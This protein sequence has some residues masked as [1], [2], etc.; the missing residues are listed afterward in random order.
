MRNVIIIGGV[1]AGCKAAARLSRLCPDYQ[2]TI[3]EKSEFISFSSCGLPFYASGDLNDLSDLNKTSY[4]IVRDSK[5]FQEVK[6][7]R[8]LIETEVLKL[9][10]EKKKVNCKNFQT[11]DVFE[12]QYDYL[13]LSTG[14]EAVKPKFAYP[15]TPLI[16]SFHTPADAKYFRQLAQ[17][18]KIR[19]AVIVG[20][21]FVGCEMI[22]ALT[23]LW[24]IETVMIE[25]EKTILSS[26][27]DPEISSFVE[28][29]IKHDNIHLMLGNS[30]N[31]IDVDESG[32]PVVYLD[33]GQIISSDFVL[34]N[35]GVMPNSS[36]AKEA[37]IKVGKCGGII[38][39]E[40][41]RTS[42]PNI[43]AAG[44]CV[45]IK[46]FVKDK[47]DYFSLGSLSNR[48]GRAAADS[49]AGTSSNNNHTSF[50]GSAGTVSLKMFD[51]IIC[52]SGLT[53][54]KAASLGYKT[55]SVIGC[56][57]DRPDY[58]PDSKNI[59]GKLV[60]EKLGMKLLG[61]Q[62]VSE[63]EVTRYI[64]L[65]SEMLSQNKSV[66]D[67]LNTEHAYTPAH[68]NPVS[69]LNYLG[70]MAINQEEDGVRCF[71]PLKI[72][73]FSGTFIDVR[74]LSETDSS[75]N[76]FPGYKYPDRTIQAPLSNLRMNLRNFNIEQPLMFICEKGV[77]S[78]EAA[79]I[80]KNHGYK[81]ISYLGGG[82]LLY[83]NL[84]TQ[85]AL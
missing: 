29:C 45:E 20:G 35:L 57:Y 1:A 34:Y 85:E 30:V 5:Y 3:I 65:F 54:Q 62:L 79:R 50:K 82:S 49:I 18:G 48:M 72:P 7:V 66:E 9:D 81:N 76:K 71:C 67:L 56:W 31:K 8:A 26:I 4:G 32:L 68:S 39:D 11:G 44:D 27:L 42:A 12:L 64:D 22:E 14:S 60:Y 6:G 69:P 78:Y 63:G 77:R 74:E 75:G 41:M 19:K 16:S 47:P 37:G 15:L 40:Q 59:L 58:H 25:K 13:I 61:L 43:W 21:G 83:N 55:G 51:D 23:S 70:Y 10:I 17:K 24:E 80:F 2:I 38:V 28:S 84:K 36:L 53:E 52:A 46:N 73:E 33:N